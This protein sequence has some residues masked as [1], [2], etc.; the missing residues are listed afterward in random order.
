MSTDRSFHDLIRMVIAVTAASALI[1]ASH[2]GAANEFRPDDAGFRS[3]A[4]PFLKQHCERCHGPSK[5]EA[6]FR[7]DSD[8]P[9]AFLDRAAK[10]KWSEVVNVLNSHQMPPDDE[11]QP[12]PADVAKIVDWIVDQMSRAELHRRESAI[13][14]RRLNREEYRNTIRDLTGVDFDVSGFPQDPPAGGFDNNGSAL[15]MSPLQMELYL[16]AARKILNRALVEGDQP[17]AI[18]WRFH[19]EVGDGDDSRVRYD[20]FNAIVHGGK[21]AVEGDFK[22]MHHDSWDRHLNARDYKLKHEGSYVLRVHAGGRVPKRDAVVEAARK[23]LDHRFKEQ[24]EKNPKG[25]KWH[26]MARDHD[27]LH[28]QNHPMYD[29]GPPR[30]KLIL[31]LG[32]QPRTVAEFDV[33]APATKPATYE[34]R[35]YVIP[36]RAGVTVEYCYSIPRE[37]ENFWMQGNDGFARPEALVDWFEVEGPVFESWPPASHAMLL[38]DS[39]LR[40]SD[41]SAY[42]REAI[43]RFMRRA[44]RRP[45]TAEEV[46]EKFAFYRAARERSDRFVPAIRAAFTTVLC[47]PHFLYLSEPQGGASIAG[48]AAPSPAVSSAKTAPATPSA[49]SMS[50]TK[51]SSTKTPA[52]AATP[53]ATPPRLAKS[54]SKA[55]KPTPQDAESAEDPAERIARIR[56]ALAEAQGGRKPKPTA[57][58]AVDVA[59]SR[60]AAP[61]NNEA[62]RSDDVPSTEPAD[63]ATSARRLNDSEFASRLS[64]FLWSSMPDETLFAE[65]ESGGLRDPAAIKSQI[66][67][68]IDDA[69]SDALVRNF[70]GQWLGLREVGANPPA[71]DLYPQYDRHL[72]SSFTAES[73][74]FFREILRSDESVMC[75][76]KSDWVTINERLARHYGIPNVRGDEFRRV[77]VPQG[78]KRGG[79]VTQGAVL[80]ITSNGTR[81]SPVK[82]GVWVMKNVLGIDPGLPVANAGDIAPK[83]PGIDKATV[84]QRLEI[85]RTLPQCARCH[86]QIDPLGFALENYNAAGSWRDQEGF[87]YKG[88]IERNDPKI[89][90]RS[91]LPDGTEIDGVVDLQAA[92][93]KREDLFL[94]CLATKLSTYALGRELGVAD[95]PHIKASVA[96]LKAN[97]YTLASLIEFIVQS[98]A[99]GSK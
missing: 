70:A 29:Y 94:T 68:M 3:V 36:D 48:I 17:P 31:D 56:A 4:T 86:N 75:F 16:D 10:E 9:N 40:K 45:V 46:D 1:G 89:D 71:A 21:N 26:A 77:A 35:A 49:S 74:A 28:F 91:K 98:P 33:D 39:P 61:T 60:N 47:S 50:S 87:G 78:V 11:P 67:R 13:V 80:T 42:A 90:A 59:E 34:F 96:H 85:H 81:T 22:V 19:P 15:A 37:L 69:R 8:L 62:P 83:V 6:K 72:E 2:A 30:L 57:P 12:K 20:E 76:V 79:V 51:A 63:A 58:P 43:T 65:A 14:L 82:R 99:F 97:R 66:R 24:M 25:E 88:R 52:T 41:E 95:Q 27:L 32:G 18:K 53:S 54:G 93:L 38:F 92:L 7:I 55:A 44:Y 64:Y 84:R 73:Q 23:F 5:Q